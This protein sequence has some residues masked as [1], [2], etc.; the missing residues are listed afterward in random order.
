LLGEPA[1]VF[2]SGT[3]VTE[4]AVTANVVP[5]VSFDHK[6][7]CSERLLKCEGDDSL[8]VAADGL[9]RD[10]LHTHFIGGPPDLR[11]SV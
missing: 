7:P 11:V 2:V 6:R 10:V 3:E 1:G 9:A 5:Y 8:A 4:R